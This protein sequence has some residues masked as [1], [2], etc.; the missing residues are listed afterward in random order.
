MIACYSILL[1]AIA[2]RFKSRVRLEAEVLMLRHQVNVLRRQP[3]G[4][5]R[6]TG[7]ARLVFVLLYRLCPWVL[8]AVAVI[9]PAT[10]IRWHRNGFRADWHWKA[11]ARGGRPGV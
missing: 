1:N 9:K 6:L 7:W 10:V 3:G 5:P 8:N 11:R 4:R 2:I